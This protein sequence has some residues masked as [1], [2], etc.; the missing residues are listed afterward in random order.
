MRS[1]G[2]L[3][4]LVLGL[5]ASLGAAESEP[6]AWDQSRV[7]ELASQLQEAVKGL[8]DSARKQGR[9]TGGS[10]QVRA[11]NRLLDRLRLIEAESRHLAAS[12]G[13]GAGRDE[14]EP[15]FERL[16]LLRRDAAEEA[17][18]LFMTKPLMDRIETA[19]G[20]LEELRPYYQGPGQA[21]PSVLDREQPRS[22]GD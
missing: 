11:Y 5:A 17:R 22:E 13:G 2:I 20:V 3:L 4:I 9:P 7:S 6:I 14:T 15:V 18:R 21:P 8:R 19:R 12:L 10:G 16:D 1:L